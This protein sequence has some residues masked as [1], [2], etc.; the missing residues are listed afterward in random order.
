MPAISQQWVWKVVWQEDKALT[1]MRI[2]SGVDMA[3]VLAKAKARQ[4]QEG[5]LGE[6]VQITRKDRIN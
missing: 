1:Y 4:T 5:F 6:I 2:F 3:R